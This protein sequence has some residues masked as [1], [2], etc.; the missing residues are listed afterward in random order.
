MDGGLVGEAA[1]IRALEEHWIAGAALDVFAIESL[2]V[3]SQLWELPNVILSPHSSGAME[4]YNRRATELLSEN[5]RRYLRGQ[6]LRNVV[7]E[8]RGY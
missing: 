7:D 4:D 2:P 6:K 3:D 8:K 5:L 1:L